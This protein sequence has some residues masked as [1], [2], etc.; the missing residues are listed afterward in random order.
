MTD[1][2]IE[3]F[4]AEHWDEEFPGVVWDDS[5]RTVIDRDMFLVAIGRAS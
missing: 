3:E 5:G 1:D 2:E 4:L